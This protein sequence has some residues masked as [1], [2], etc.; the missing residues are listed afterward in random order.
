MNRCTISF[1]GFHIPHKG[2]VSTKKLMA[3]TPTL[4]FVPPFVMIREGDE[5]MICCSTYILLLPDQ[6]SF[7]R[8][9]YKEATCQNLF[10]QALH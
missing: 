10:G 4:K 5:F 1:S 9:A 8:C 2:K 3:S 7:G 6:I